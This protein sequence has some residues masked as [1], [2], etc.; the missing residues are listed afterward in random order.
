MSDAGNAEAKSSASLV[1]HEITQGLRSHPEEQ[2]QLHGLIPKLLSL[3]DDRTKSTGVGNA[4]PALSAFSCKLMDIHMLA[5]VLPDI[6]MALAWVALI[7]VSCSSA[8]LS[9]ASNLPTY[10]FCDLKG[11]ANY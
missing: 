9:R 7:Q 11:L 2:Q 4:T 8:S 1:Q 5:Y 3:E 10:S 6:W